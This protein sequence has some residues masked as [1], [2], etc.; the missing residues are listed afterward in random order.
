MIAMVVDFAAQTGPVLWAM[1]AGLVILAVLIFVSV[2]PELAEVYLGDAHIFVAT[3]AL[4]AIVML[5]VVPERAAVLQQL[6]LLVP[7]R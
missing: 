4:A 5:L 3:L 1:V 2:D 6:Q 7:G